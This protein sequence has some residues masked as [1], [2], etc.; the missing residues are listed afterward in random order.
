MGQRYADFSRLEFLVLDEADRMLDMGFLPTS[1]ASCKR[2]RSKRQT[3]LFSA[4]LSQEIE[5][6][7]HEFLHAPEDRA[8]RPPLEP[9]GNRHAVRLRSAEAPQARAARCICCSDPAHEHGAR[10][11][12][13]QARRR[14]HRAASSSSS[15]IT[16]GDA[17]LEPLAKPAPARA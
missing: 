1:G 5:A 11:H 16:T 15:G 7:T 2:C 8:D 4:T 10:L 3:L 17:A 6:L 9:R 12:P 14:P 13:H